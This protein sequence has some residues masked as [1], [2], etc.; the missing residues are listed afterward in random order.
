[1]K[2]S[3]VRLVGLVGLTLACTAQAGLAQPASYPSQRITLVVAFA[4][5]GAADAIAR[6]VGPTLSRR[7]GQPVVVENRGGAA[8]SLGAGP[9]PARLPTA[10]PFW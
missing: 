10:T 7:L 6:Q 2:T 4:P 5:G 9:S 8:G 3:T 1:M